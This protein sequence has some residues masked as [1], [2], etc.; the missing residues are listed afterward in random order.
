VTEELVGRILGK[1]EL[2]K[3]LGRGGMAEVYMGYH[4]A[5]DRYT[6]I[7]ILHPFLGED[8][9][10]KD[11]FEREARNVAKLR[12]PN[13][14]QVYDFDH[15]PVQ[16]VYYMVMEFIDGPTLR[17][18]LRDLNFQGEW[19]TVTEAVRITRDL[20]S[21][22]AYAHA[23]DMV[24]RDIKPANIMMDSDGRVV[25]T[26]FGIA[27]MISGPQMTASGTMVGT[28]S[29]MSP[30]QGLGQPGDHRSDIYSLG[31]VLYQLAV[32]TLPYDAD[33]PI[34]IVLKHVNEPL[35]PP[36]SINPDIPEGLERVIYKALAKSP[37]ER[38]QSIEDMAL[39]LDDLD[40]ASTLV[41]PMTT[42]TAPT[43]VHDPVTPAFNMSAAAVAASTR[44][45][46][47]DRPTPVPAAPV[48]GPSWGLWIVLL[49]LVLAL[50]GVVGGAYATFTGLI[51][52]PNMRGEGELEEGT[53]T[54]SPQATPDDQ[55]TS[56]QGTI[57]ALAMT[58]AAAFA[59]GTTEPD[60]NMTVTALACAYDYDYVRQSPSNDSQ[61]L[62]E[63]TLEV[64]LTIVNDSRCL[65]PEDT[66]LVFVEGDQMNAPDEIA[67]DQ[68]IDPDERFTVEIVFLTPEVAGYSR[69]VG[70]TWQIELADG[71]PIGPPISLEYIIV[72]SATIPSVTPTLTGT[73]EA[74]A[75]LAFTS[76]WTPTSCGPHPSRP[77]LYVCAVQLSITGGR[78][79]YQI[80]T[81]APEPI[82]CGSLPCYVEFSAPVTCDPRPWGASVRDASGQGPVSAQFW[83]DP[84]IYSYAFADGACP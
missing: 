80:D 79:P 31:V 49:G 67:F 42:A 48:A 82:V 37:E 14:V 3:R 54:P 84:Q 11:R 78:P 39:H 77:D 53:S 61:Q 45:V 38:Y 66:S 22:L 24:H 17:V 20:A 59:A 25:L 1:Y 65:W 56:L 10:F 28:P 63:A 2:R 7:K 34:A 41:I 74:V 50:L 33:T 43:A 40:A 55:A 72:D 4:A 44:N 8:P 6:A 71:T 21:A 47:A 32:G 30:E 16:D 18:R 68:T 29:Y 52:L 23:R 46:A 64:Y 60:V 57:D 70:N 15:D 58:Q 26:D 73:P 35:P 69:R 81:G 36:S 27:R 12:H 83:F 9:E 62:E 13:I 51:P 5:L 75:P 19:L 76:Q